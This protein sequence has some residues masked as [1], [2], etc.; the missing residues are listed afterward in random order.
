M[1]TAAMKLEHLLL[2]RKVRQ[3]HHFADKVYI[4]KGMVFPVVM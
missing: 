1:V 3:R 2:G 4:V